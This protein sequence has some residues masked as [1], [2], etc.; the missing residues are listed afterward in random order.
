MVGRTK[1]HL[2]DQRVKRDVR[3]GGIERGR[4][5]EREREVERERHVERGRQ[6]EREK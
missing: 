5:L 4:Q 3:G 6:R 2:G 1:G